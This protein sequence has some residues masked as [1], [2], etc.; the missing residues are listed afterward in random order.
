[1]AWTR[2]DRGY[3]VCIS[4]RHYDQG[5]N[6]ILTFGG[7]MA[8][9]L[10]REYNLSIIFAGTAWIHPDPSLIFYV[11]LGDTLTWQYNPSLIHEGKA[12][13]HPD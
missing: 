1:M 9:I 7:S 8:S 4:R 2:L 3:N 6:P 10:T 13:I 5:Y 11:W 12:R